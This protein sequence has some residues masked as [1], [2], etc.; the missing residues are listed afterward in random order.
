MAEQ[1]ERKRAEQPEELGRFFLE[2]ANAG[3][4]DGLAALYEPDAVL[5]APQGQLTI[6]TAAIRRFYEQ[7]LAG[8]PT[9]SG[10]QQPVLRNDDLALTSTRFAGGVTVELAR[11]Q[12]DGTWLWA[13][14]QPN[15]LG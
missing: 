7:L 11:R 8:G 15:I 5:A 3:D 14:D 4:A 1:R 6:G 9:F 12:P 10:E 2:R 13:I